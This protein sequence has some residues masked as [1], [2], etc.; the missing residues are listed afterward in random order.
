MGNAIDLRGDEMEAVTY[1]G[2]VAAVCATG[3]YVPQIIKIRKQG[4]ED[5]SFP[6]LFLYLTGTLL[7]LVY[8][9]MLNA[10]A[11]IWANAITSLLVI[12]A[13]VLKMNYSPP[14]SLPSI[15]VK[16]SGMSSE[17]ES[18]SSLPSQTD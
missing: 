13:I 6:M 9:L 17:G 2:T 12:T 15:P 8:G 16:A 11:V 3:S 10:A 1:I 7:W 18:I 5:L 14:K 4:G